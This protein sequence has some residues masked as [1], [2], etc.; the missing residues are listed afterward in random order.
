[1]N[2]A[3]LL[4]DAT[5]KQPSCFDLN[6]WHVRPQASRSSQS[7]TTS[8]QGSQNYI[9]DNEILVQQMSGGGQYG[10]TSPNLAQNPDVS[11]RQVS[12]PLREQSPSTNNIEGEAETMGNMNFSAEKVKMRRE[13]N[14]ISARLSRYKKATQMQNLQ[15]Q[16]SLLE[17]ENKYLVK[18]QADLIQK[19][20]SAVIDNRVLK[21]NVETL[22][23]KVKLVEEI[24][25]RFTSTH[26]VPQVV[27]SLTSLGFPLSASPSNGAHETFV[28]TQNTP[29]NYFTSVTTNGGVNNIYTP[30]ATSTFQIQDPVALLQMQS[31]SSLEH[32]QRRVCDSAPSSSVL[33][34]QEVTSFN[35][36]EFIN[37]GM[38]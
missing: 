22:E 26:D 21:A 12:S 25:K 3:K 10:G 4:H 38:Q 1:M 8:N 5:I 28:P 17:A 29:F 23:T 37:M 36:N 27:S 6:F 18:R 19:Y 20:S 16:L 34:P 14:R 9:G 33:A 31:E 13:S 11:V 24:I 35:P 7:N 2:C 30:E 32:L 15:H